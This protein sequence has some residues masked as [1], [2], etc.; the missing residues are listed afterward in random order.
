AGRHSPAEN[1]EARL[2][3]IAHS[4]S[5]YR[6]QQ[7]IAYKARLAG[8]RVEWVN[9]KETSRTWPR[10]GAGAKYNPKGNRVRGG[11]GGDPRQPGGRR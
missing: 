8:I 1:P 11:E 6:L 2:R 9:P 7:F 5:F 3:A 10:G 4:W